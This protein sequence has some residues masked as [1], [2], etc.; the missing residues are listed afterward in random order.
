M[1][2]PIVQAP[3]TRPVRPCPPT[4][5]ELERL[6]VLSLDLLCIASADGFFK[7]VNPAATEL[8]GWSTE[9]LLAR[10]LIEFVHPDDRAATLDEIRRQV[11]AGENVLH[12]E[13]RYRHRDGSWRVLAWRSVPQPGGLMFASARDVTGRRADEAEIR[14][15]SAE[16][17]ALFESLP[18][19]YLILT[20]AFEIVTASDAYLAATMTCRADITGRGLFEVFP[21]N[22]GD[23]KAD[24]VRNLRASLERVRHTLAPDTMA[25]QKYDVRRPDGTFE[26]RHWSPINSPMIDPDGR[27]AYII[28][29]VED[30]T[31]FVRRQTAPADGE[32]GI[33]LRARLGQ[34][35]A[36]VFQSTQAV[37]AANEQ[38]R[39]LNAELEAFSYS[40]S[41]D[42][43]APLRHIDGFALL[44]QK[45]ADTRLDEQSRR[46][47]ATITASAKRLGLLIDELLMF[48][49]MG[50]A[51]LRH[52]PVEPRAL[53]DEVVREL[54]H[55]T[56]GRPIEW[57]LSALPPV[58]ADPAMLRQVWVNLLGNAVKYT[59]GR[60][61]ARIEVF[62]LPGE[63]G[64]RVFAVRDN[65]A[66]FDM[67]Y[68]GKLFGV[69]QRLHG[70]GEFEGTGIGLANVRRIVTR[71]GGRTWAEGRLGEGATFFFS[72]PRPADRSA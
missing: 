47:L 33:A 2:R 58:S 65:G 25:I 16:L 41:H 36:E 51:E 68:A 6:F 19:L 10:P 64:E 30:V 39:A 27:L 71:H 42:L 20:P 14:R 12:F 5:Q 32:D 37:Q 57:Q 22:P 21:D 49:R 38:L 31:E 17:R 43:R 48:S 11:V 50:R 45:R 69:F 15:L 28:H 63:D 4:A 55:E 18:G 59:R 60:A 40:V 3:A 1:S 8:L 53:V 7:R 23:P 9:E 56:R 67:K 72:L 61:P 34:M 66:G 54:E 70:E 35:E 26:E 13:N 62:A 24:G 52:T 44:L 29:R 46:Y